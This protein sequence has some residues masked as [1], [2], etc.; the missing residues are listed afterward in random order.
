MN[1]NYEHAL[2]KITSVLTETLHNM[3]CFNVYVFLHWCIVYMF[4][5]V[6]VH[7]VT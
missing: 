3:P 5:N 6:S 4:S 7:N 1:T 2:H